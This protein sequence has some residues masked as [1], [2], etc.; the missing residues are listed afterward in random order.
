MREAANFLLTSI[1]F[2]VEANRLYF[3]AP[4]QIREWK[5]LEIPRGLT[6][7]FEE[8]FLCSFFSDPM[9]V[10]KLSFFRNRQALPQLSLNAEQGEYLTHILLQI[11][12][13][14]AD[15][16]ETHLLRAL[17]YQV[18]AWLNNVYRSQNSLEEK[19]QNP[20][21]A[22]FFQLVDQHC[23][24]EHTV[25]F[26]A[27]ELCITSGYLNDLV[28]KETGMSAK[29]YIISRLMAESKKML[30]QGELSVSEIAWKLGFGD[31]SYFIRLFRN[32]TGI[33][34]LAFRKQQLS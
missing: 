11:E 21:V 4:G 6:V 18:L 26:Y 15:N 5:V 3:T 23:F 16:K 29:Q 1:V 24:S 12:Q 22:R 19:S 14:I 28:K 34:P 9:F 25:L 13:E 27:S 20:K 10:K 30:Q 7:I 32:E 2:P 17:L 33:P 8:E 31:S